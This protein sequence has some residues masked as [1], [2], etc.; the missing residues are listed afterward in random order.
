MET[1]AR[2]SDNAAAME[3]LPNLLDRIQVLVDGRDPSAP[4][5]LLERMEHTLTDGYARAL[6][7][8]GEHLRIARE[9]GAAAAESSRAAAERLGALAER[10]HD[11]EG[12]LERLRARLVPL[13]QQTRELASLTRSRS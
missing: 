11:T 6:A 5:R 12:E 10:L 13:R 9:I 1:R 8:E 2:A 3:D 7:L 4:E